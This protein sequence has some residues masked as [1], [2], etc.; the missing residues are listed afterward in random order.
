[1][2][3]PAAVK[4]RLHH[5]C[6]LRRARALRRLL[7][8]RDI[9][10]T[11]RHKLI[12]DASCRLRARDLPT[13]V[14]FQGRDAKEARPADLLCITETASTHDAQYAGFA[15]RVALHS[16]SPPFAPGIEATALANAPGLVSAN[17]GAKILQNVCHTASSCASAYAFDCA[18]GT[19]R[20][21][22]FARG[23]AR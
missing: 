3:L 12:P 19:V 4:A 7:P 11:E 16:P 20:S 18:G 22:W 13:K 6:G 2:S 1:M 17:A 5:F 14:P 23:T 10:C 8:R 9:S 15:V 21:V